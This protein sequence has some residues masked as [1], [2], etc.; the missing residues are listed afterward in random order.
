MGAERQAKRRLKGS[1]SEAWD[2]IDKATPSELDELREFVELLSTGEG[3][4]KLVTMHG[5]CSERVSP[6]SANACDD[7]EEAP[8]VK[9]V[10]LTPLEFIIAAQSFNVA[11]QEHAHELTRIHGE[12]I[13]ADLLR[14]LVSMPQRQTADGGWSVERDL[15]ALVEL[16]RA[17]TQSTPSMRT[18][19]GEPTTKRGGSGT[20]EARRKRVLA[21]RDDLMS[22]LSPRVA[23]AVIGLSAGGTNPML[24]AAPI[25]PGEVGMRQPRSGY[26]LYCENERASMKLFRPDATTEQL[27][28]LLRK[29]WDALM[30][31]EKDVYQAR[32]A[33]EP[34]VETYQQTVPPPMVLDYDAAV[35]LQEGCVHKPMPF[36]HTLVGTS[37]VGVAAHAHIPQRWPLRIGPWQFLL[38]NPRDVLSGVKRQQPTRAYELADVTRDATVGE[39]AADIAA[40]LRESLGAAA[41]CGAPT[42]Q[43][44]AATMHDNLTTSY[45]VLSPEAT[46]RDAD[47]FNLGATNEY[48]RDPC[49]L[50]VTTQIPP[51]PPSARADAPRTPRR[52]VVPSRPPLATQDPAVAE[53]PAEPDVP[54]PPE[55]LDALQRLR[56][57]ARDGA[58]NT[59]PLAPDHNPMLRALIAAPIE[60][61]ASTCL[62]TTTAE[63]RKLDGHLAK[64]EEQ[65]VR[66]CFNCGMVNYPVSGDKIVVTASGRDDLRAWRVYGPSI[67][68][69]ATERGL[70][71]GDVFLCEEVDGD[72]SKRRVYTCTACKKE[73]CQDPAQYDLFDGH[74]ADA[75]VARGW[76]YTS[77]GVGEPPPEPLAELTSDERLL[78][79]VVKMADASFEPA[80]SSTGYTRFSNGGLLQPGDYHGLAAILVQDETQHDARSVESAVRLR[81]ALQFLMDPQRGNPLVRETLTCFEREVRTHERTRP[82][83][84]ATSERAASTRTCH[85]LHKWT[86]MRSRPVQGQGRYRSWRGTIRHYAIRL[87]RMVQPKLTHLGKVRPMMMAFESA[88]RL[89]ASSHRAASLG[90]CSQ[91]S[92][93]RTM[94]CAAKTPSIG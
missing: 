78:L 63:Y 48:E 47:L 15:E 79:G 8:S 1:A 34:L 87:V 17:R 94:Q 51:C 83:P 31:S 84:R 85:S 28:T 29:E 27:A 9:P 3:R 91:S 90:R 32:A 21:M 65:A 43:L 45:E 61:P 10:P 50:I 55:L 20:A 81:R 66:C 72:D 42:V 54:V 16:A 36:G 14:E 88:P 73:K 74:A 7:A 77:N 58:G 13:V 40:F 33:S 68:A 25:Y 56:F 38:D 18:P 22:R 82:A 86:T 44:V 11:V 49:Q 64:V 5:A 69:F 23:S 62:P 30:D 92:S 67:Q 4:A 6:T 35:P 75:R 60:H 71:E 24:G 53:P 59:R 57:V 41:L 2:L 76:S 37:T 93:H 80:Y 26:A 46:A 52:K 70:D 89:R 39:I 19:E 12:A